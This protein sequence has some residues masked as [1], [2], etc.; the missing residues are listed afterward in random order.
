MDLLRE[1]HDEG[2]TIVLVTHDPGV[3]AR[4]DRLI[5]VKDGDA[6]RATSCSPSPEH[7][8]EEAIGADDPP[9][10]VLVAA[11]S[12]PFL[13]VLA[14][15]PVLRR[16]AVRN[17]VRRP[18]EAALVVLGS[19][20]GAAIITGS[21]VVGDTIN[22]SIRQVARTQLGPI[23][24]LVAARR[25][26]DQHQLIRSAAAARAR[27]IDGVLPFATVD[28]AATSTGRASARGAA[29]AG[30]RRRLRRARRFGGDPA[31]TGVSG[32][33]PAPGHAAITDDLARALGV[34]S[35]GRIAVYAYGARTALV[36]DRVFPRRG[37]AGFWL[38]HEQ[39]ANN[40]LVS[41]QTFDRDR[42]GDGA[43]AR[44]RRGASRSRTAAASRAARPDRRRRRP[45]AR[46]ARAAGLDP[47][48]YPAKRHAARRGRR[49]S[50]RAS[51]TMFTAMGSFGVLAGLLLLVNLFVM[52]AAE[53][54]TEMGMARAVGMRRCELVGAFATEGWIYAL[55][56]TAARR[57]RGI[58]LGAC[59]SSLSARAFSSE[60]NQFDLFFTLRPASLA[61][62]FARR[63]PS[64]S[65]RSSA[66]ACG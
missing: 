4:A 50:A 41:P 51:R 30:H 24:E 43:R 34:A 17:A 45:D 27:E 65:S 6:R 5:T 36:V 2:L 12:L 8:P 21:F 54:K 35:G 59:S 52:L 10:V 28:A 37:V 49:R 38:G 56:A 55:A 66:R 25:A 16:L 64:R 18:R 40:V 61:Q 60:H 26:G 15:R 32:P 63:S 9:L 62:A 20:L 44:R 1:L 13:F 39:E 48:I 33:T 11:L 29:L 22:A 47:Q 42:V 3:A 46:R 53:R 57:R 31:A 23:D 7:V 19:L 14:R 58:G